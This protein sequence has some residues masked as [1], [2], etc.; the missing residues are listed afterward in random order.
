MAL[1]TQE[2]KFHPCCSVWHSF[3]ITCW[4]L[5]VTLINQSPI[6]TRYVEELKNVFK[7]VYK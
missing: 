7:N 5:F 4:H 3:F 1:E 6:L 2:H